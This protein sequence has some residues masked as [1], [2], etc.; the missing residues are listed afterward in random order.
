MQ[1]QVFIDRYGILKRDDSYDAVKRLY[2]FTVEEKRRGI[3]K[4]KDKN[5]YLLKMQAEDGGTPYRIMEQSSNKAREFAFGGD[6]ALMTIDRSLLSRYINGAPME[7]N[8]KT[9]DVKFDTGAGRSF[10][11]KVG[12]VF[13]KC[14]QNVGDFFLIYSQAIEDSAVMRSIEDLMNKLSTK[15]RII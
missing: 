10:H 7:V 3:G 2:D 12:D 9:T 1:Y 5:V 15:Y 4:F 6:V 14:I 11:V 13:I 8:D